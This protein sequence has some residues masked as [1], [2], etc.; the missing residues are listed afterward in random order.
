MPHL[1]L[2]RLCLCLSLLAA[3]SSRNIFAQDGEIWVLL[4]LIIAKS[5]IAYQPMTGE[6]AGAEVD[7]YATFTLYFV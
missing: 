4:M 5:R 6:T 3:R 7:H 1:S 2:H